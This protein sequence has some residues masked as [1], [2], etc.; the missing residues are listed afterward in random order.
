MSVTSELSS[1]V[2]AALLT[3]P[4]PEN[5]E[6]LLEVLLVM[7]ATL[8]KLSD[9]TRRRRFNNRYGVTPPSYMTVVSGQN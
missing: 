4:Q 7:R 6:A 5:R 1:E 2:A 3:Q 8:R 9:D